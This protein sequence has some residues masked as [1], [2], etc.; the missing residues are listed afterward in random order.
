[1]HEVRQFLGLCGYYRHCVRNCA[2]VA[3]PLHD[4]TKIGEQLVWTEERDTA[5]E[6]LK[7]HLVT[8]P[9]LAMSQDAGSYTFDVDASNWGAGTVLLP[10]QDGFLRV[11][12]YAS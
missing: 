9:I 11:I 4:M 7:T 6:T 3:A 8:V 12:S 2:Q 5:Y 1:V 10:E